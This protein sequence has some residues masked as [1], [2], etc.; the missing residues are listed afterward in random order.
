M[1]GQTDENAGVEKEKC[2][3]PRNPSVAMAM[4]AY[5]ALYSKRLGGPTSIY[6]FILRRGLRPPD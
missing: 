6:S 2:P 1:Q 4:V 5:I 3:L